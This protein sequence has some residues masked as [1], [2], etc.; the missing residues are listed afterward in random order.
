MSQHSIT[1]YPL[2]TPQISRPLR[3]QP[4]TSSS[5]QSTEESLASSSKVSQFGLSGNFLE[6]Q[7][8]EDQEIVEINEVNQEKLQ[9]FIGTLI[10]RKAIFVE[11]RKVKDFRDY[12]RNN[13]KLKFD[14]DNSVSFDL[15][16]RAAVLLILF[17]DFFVKTKEEAIGM[18]EYS[19][20]ELFKICSSGTFTTWANMKSKKV[21]SLDSKERI[22]KRLRIE[23]NNMLNY[24]QSIFLSPSYLIT[25]N[26]LDR[27]LFP[28]QVYN[29]RFTKYKYVAPFFDDFVSPNVNCFDPNKRKGKCGPILSILRYFD[30]LM[31]EINK[32]V[33]ELNEVFETS[34]DAF[35]L[36]SNDSIT[37]IH[38]QYEKIIEI[39][40]AC[41]DEKSKDQLLKD[42]DYFKHHVNELITRSSFNI[43]LAGFRDEKHN[44]LLNFFY[45]KSEEVGYEK[46]GHYMPLKN[47]MMQFTYK[48]LELFIG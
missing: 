20:V 48:I 19:V 9:S 8:D 23:R 37:T 26:A 15:V 3:A 47:F 12:L 11:G 1:P 38:E 30:E 35:T 24:W 39:H 6:N 43:L 31:N 4:F 46:Y 45:D 10:I 41:A 13:L 44:H 21:K 29:T 17:K 33:V 16:M 22:W 18:L 27:Q 14:D 5:R 40:A 32:N 42:L 28:T 36:S 2:N 7:I 34:F 25:G